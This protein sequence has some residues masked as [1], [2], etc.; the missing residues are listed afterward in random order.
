[1]SGGFE[2]G[3][4]V[5]M[6]KKIKLLFSVLP[7]VYKVSI[8]NIQRK[9]FESE[10]FIL[11]KL[12]GRHDVCLDIGGAYGRYSYPM[13][14]LAREGRIL[15][16]EPGQYSFYILSLVKLIFRMKNVEII[17]KALGKENKK[18]F[19]ISPIKRK[20]KIGHSL[21]Y[22]SDKVVPSA[23]CEPVEVT[24]IDDVVREHSIDSLNF[25]KCDTEG[26]EMLVLWGGVQTIK[27][28]RPVILAEV[29][30]KHLNRFGNSVQEVKDFFKGLS[31][32]FFCL[33][34][35]RLSKMADIKEDSNY[36]FIPQEKNLDF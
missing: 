6:F 11:E 3:K 17:K 21:S 7:M 8:R 18:S 14:R 16:F 30:A 4:G 32:D 27:K 31:Y 34:D 2:K 13:A 33:I 12:I 29:D 26:A 5:P 19:L 23:K 28:F 20:E 22:L 35:G 36:F 24:T 15:T 1:M 10:V 9:K 25:I